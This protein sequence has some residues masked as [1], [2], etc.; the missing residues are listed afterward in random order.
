M[1]FEPHLGRLAPRHQR[2]L[3]PPPRS[4]PAPPQGVSTYAALVEAARV[5]D[6]RPL[7]AIAL[8]LLWLLAT[9]VTVIPVIAVDAV[10]QTNSTSGAS[11]VS[12]G[13]IGVPAI[14]VMLGGAALAFAALGTPLL[15]GVYANAIRSVR[16][17]EPTCR[18][19]LVGFRLYPASFTIGALVGVISVLVGIVPLAGP[20]LSLLAG[21]CT[22][23]V[24]G[25]LADRRRGVNDALHVGLSLLQGRLLSLV[26]LY[27]CAGLLG[28]LGA[29]LACLGLIFT[30]P[31]MA[32]MLGAGYRDAVDADGRAD[33][34]PEGHGE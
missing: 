12:M 10:A 9:G 1:V 6:R 34:Q 20:L 11:T 17:G 32:L 2:E 13:G 14:V 7:A 27:L 26:L 28:L 15:V 8:G 19:W 21:T 29:A 30:V 16:E 25:A 18:D 33:L 23:M 5:F 3:A 31:I 22:W 4:F 24:L